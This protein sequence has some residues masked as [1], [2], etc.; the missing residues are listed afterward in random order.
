MDSPE[1]SQTIATIPRDGVIS[2]SP[3]VAVVVDLGYVSTRLW[4]AFQ[5]S[6]HP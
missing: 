6:R 5:T 1:N 4:G 2:C 3:V